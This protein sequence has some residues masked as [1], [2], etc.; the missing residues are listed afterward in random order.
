MKPL[1]IELELQNNQIKRIK[2]ISDGVRL[3]IEGKSYFFQGGYLLPGFIDSHLHLFGIGENEIV[4]NFK[5]ITSAEEIISNI[6]DSPFF[7]NNW[8]TGFGWNEENFAD[9]KLPDKRMLDLAFPNIPVCLKRVDGHAVWVNSIA[10]QIAG[11]SKHPTG[12]LVDTAKDNVLNLIPKYSN[13]QIIKMILKAQEILF[14]FGITEVCDM[15]TD[16]E[17][18]EIYK[19]LDNENALQIKVHSYISAQYDDYLRYISQPYLGNMF[20]IEGIKLFA[21]GALGS[22]GA[23]LFEPYNDDANNSG[24][25]QIQPEL[26]YKKMQVA[27]DLGF[28]IATHAIGD[29]A[30]HIILDLYQ[31]LSQKYINKDII[32][33]VEHCQMVH[34]KDLIKFS[35]PRIFASVQPIHYVSDTKGMAQSRIGK[36]LEYSYPWKSIINYGGTLLSGSDAPIESPDPILG[37]DALIHSERPDQILD[38]ESAIDTYITNPR[39][40]FRNNSNN[41]INQNN[42][43]FSETNFV[44]LNNDLSQ[45]SFNRTYVVATIANG[46]IVYIDN[47]YGV[48]NE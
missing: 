8:I 23:S 41:Q 18:I 45:K 2:N 12:I 9:K 47:K 19:N 44:I 11:I 28:Q 34:P 7:R 38:M 22:R 24:K 21:D 40:L 31:K 43:P 33:R 27:I 25:I 1:Q 29:N 10:L 37:L 30:N 26:L 48:I 13:S 42:L 36:R 32:L 5:D 15:D 3:I 17:L 20:S 16:P 35:N 46:N 4:P 14:Q 6:K 39:K